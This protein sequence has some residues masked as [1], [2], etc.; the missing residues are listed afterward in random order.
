[1]AN[2]PNVSPLS[3]LSAD[4]YKGNTFAQEAVITT[5]NTTLTRISNNPNRVA[6]V[7]INEGLTDVRVSN[8]PNISASSGWLLAASGGVIAMKWD[9]DGE[10]VGYEIYLIS[11]AGTPNVRI[12]EVIRL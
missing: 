10:A 11:V 2:S 1:M 4:K 3:D 8:L 9:E 5:S 12:R 6:W 7:M